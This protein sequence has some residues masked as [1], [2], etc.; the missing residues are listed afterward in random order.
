MK[1]NYL[2]KDLSIVL[3]SCLVL[4][5]QSCTVYKS[6]PVS[7][8]EAAFVAEKCKVYYKNSRTQKCKRLI[9]DSD[10]YYCLTRKNWSKD[11]PIDGEQVNYVNQEDRSGSTVLNV[12]LG[13]MGVTAVIYLAS[14][15]F[16][17][18]TV[19][20]LIDAF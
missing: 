17:T 12:A 10:A 20:T 7:L 5:S 18:S 19:N 6:V 15:L 3:M 13:L 4:L 14:H 11:V 1:L 8:D 9:K 16:F 2:I